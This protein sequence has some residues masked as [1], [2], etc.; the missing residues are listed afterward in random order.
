MVW[1]ATNQDQLE[2]IRHRV[3]LRSWCICTLPC[4][5]F[6][7]RIIYGFNV[8]LLL[9]A[10]NSAILDPGA[11]HENTLRMCFGRLGAIGIHWSGSGW[12]E[13]C[14]P[15]PILAGKP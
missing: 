2:S 3:L 15:W 5:R 7:K 8:L 13:L 10:E 6:W 14:L 11:T 12:N 4:N 1:G 9:Y